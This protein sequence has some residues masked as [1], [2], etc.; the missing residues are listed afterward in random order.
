MDPVIL[1][2]SIY[3]CPYY[4]CLYIRAI[5][6]KCPEIKMF[7]NVEINTLVNSVLSDNMRVTC[8]FLLAG[9]KL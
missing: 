3:A 8:L 1:E 4:Y 9:K 2:P 6:G 7:I 5:R